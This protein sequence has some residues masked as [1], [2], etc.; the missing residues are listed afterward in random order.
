MKFFFVTGMVAA[1]ILLIALAFL[2][3]GIGPLRLQSGPVDASET[4][5]IE[6]PASAQSGLI[7]SRPAPQDTTGALP[8]P[9]FKPANFV[10]PSAPPTTNGPTAAPVN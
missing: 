7:G 2:S 6:Y 10:G 9:D 4:S 1:I 5:K 8:S 3:D